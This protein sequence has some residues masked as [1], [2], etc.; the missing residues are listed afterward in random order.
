M[1]KSSIVTMSD[2]FI[3]PADEPWEVYVTT[4]H[5]K[6]EVQEGTGG[7]VVVARDK[8]HAMKLVD[9]ELIRQGLLPHSGRMYTL[10][11]ISTLTPYSELISD[12]PANGGHDPRSKKARAVSPP[13]RRLGLSRLFVCW[14]HHS[15]VRGVAGAIMIADGPVLAG[16][17]LDA[18]L[19]RRGLLPNRRHSH[20][21]YGFD[22]D[23]PLVSMLTV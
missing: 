19:V 15:H 7:I 12:A 17:L 14:D 10:R 2:K 21:V 9:S 5:D 6:F 22:L 18:S 13:S 1:S 4:D 16:E 3:V 20:T 8:G 23:T 11:P